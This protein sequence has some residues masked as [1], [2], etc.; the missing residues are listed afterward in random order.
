MAVPV[1]FAGQT[2]NFGP[3]P[4][5]EERVG[6]LPCLCTGSLVVSAWQFSRVQLEELIDSGAPIYVSVWSGAAVFPIYVG[7]RQE[8]NSVILDFGGVIK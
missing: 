7:D 4:G 6:N 8:M 3:P 5:E 1:E 2:H